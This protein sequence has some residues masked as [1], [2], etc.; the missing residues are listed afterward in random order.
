MDHKSTFVKRFGDLVA[1]FRADPGN[2]AA[3]ELALSAAAAAV[4]HDPLRVQAG[5]DGNAIPDHPSL[6]ARMLARQVDSFSVAAG[7]TPQELEALARALAHDVT[8]IPTSPHIEV[9]L[10]RLLARPPDS[11]DG[12]EGG[13]PGSGSTGGWQPDAAAKRRRGTDRR[14]QG[15]R[16]HSSRGRWSDG[17][18]RH[19]GDR[20]L[21]GERRLYLVEDQRAQ[22]AGLF[23]GL[24]RSTES[25]AWE[26]VL[27][28][29]YSLV[30]IAT[31][32]P[33]TERHAFEIQ[34]RRA[35]PRATIEALVHLA[36]RD[37]VV[38][39]RAAEVLRW[40]GLEAAEAILDRLRQGEALGVRVFFYEV[41]G[42]MPAAYPL[43]APMLRSPLP[44]EVRHGATLLGRLG[45]PEAADVLQPALDHPDELV[46]SAVVLALGELHAAPVMDALR[47]A[48]HHQSA[49]TRVAA[50][51]A[52]VNWRGGALAALLASALEEERDRDAWQAMIT[53]LGMIGTAEACAALA[54][55]ALTPRSILRRRGY[56]TGQ[57]L[58][59][60]TAL[61]L[62]DN[63]AGH[64][65]L[66]RL[67]QEDEGVISY[68]AD[69]VLQA[70]GL[71][72]G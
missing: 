60:V 16:R 57:R 26:D 1:L 65:T 3:Q 67:A 10:V 56:S 38:R 50:A 64:T 41:V 35:V 20:R 24:S 43:V 59:A 15:D 62:A 22:I 37:Y 72:V 61:G 30:Q 44:H 58:A 36:E 4:A 32:V 39:D 9:E 54:T 19:G 21:L 13:S 23:S 40:I 29:I 69:K 18:R 34:V 53:A 55:I 45:L 5:V 6:M 70:E 49:R 8:P 12:G 28:G 17:E 71:R 52:I 14:Q 51:E 68:A 48:L 33:R 11:P 7:A 2:D 47:H 25:N 31:R 42:R 46:R 63:A 27:H 66:Q